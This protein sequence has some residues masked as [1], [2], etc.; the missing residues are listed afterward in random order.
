VKKEEENKKKKQ[1]CSEVSVNSHKSRRVSPEDV[2]P[3]AQFAAVAYDK[4]RSRA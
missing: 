1:I 3:D 2:S 4:P